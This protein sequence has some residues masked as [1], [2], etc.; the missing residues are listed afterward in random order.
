MITRGY[1]GQWATHPLIVCIVVSCPVIAFQITQSFSQLGTSQ[2]FDL[3]T[4]KLR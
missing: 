1:D 2:Q 3:L 4:N